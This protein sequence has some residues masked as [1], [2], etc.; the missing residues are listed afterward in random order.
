MKYEYIKQQ[1]LAREL[2]K[3][4]FKLIKVIND[5]DNPTERNYLF[6]ASPE[7]KEAM[8]KAIEKQRKYCDGKSKYYA[9]IRAYK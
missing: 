9:T 7:I 2:Y 5:R 1:W 4:G 8:L 3:R 6:E